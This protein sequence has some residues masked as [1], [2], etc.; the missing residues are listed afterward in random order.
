MADLITEMMGKEIK[1]LL[2]AALQFLHL[3]QDQDLPVQDLERP[4]QE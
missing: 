4:D 2:M 3:D 1:D